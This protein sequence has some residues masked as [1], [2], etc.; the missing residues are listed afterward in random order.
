M[1]QQDEQPPRVVI[2]DKRRIDPTS[3]AAR[4]PAEDRPTSARPARDEQLS[5]AAEQGEQMSE[6]DTQT[7]G[8]PDPAPGGAPAAATDVGQPLD[9][10]SDDTAQQLAERTEDLQRVTAEYANYRR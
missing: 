1:S 4:V 6:H 8:G 3:G 2:R 5:T 10:G 9:G 7:E